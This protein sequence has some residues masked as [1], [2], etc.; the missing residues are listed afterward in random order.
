MKRKSLLFLLLFAL[1]APWAANAQNTLTVYEDG[2]EVNEYVPFYGYYADEEQQ[3]QMIF[4]ATELADMVGQEITEMVFYIDHV[5]GYYSIGNWIVSLGET[6][7]TT[8]EELDL[9]TPL[10]Q[11]YSGAMN[12]NS[13]ETLM[14]VTFQVGYTYRGGNLL[15][16]FNHPE[17]ASYKHYYFTGAEVTGAAYTYDAQRDFLPKV[18]F[19]HQTP[20]AC[21]KPAFVTANCVGNSATVTWTSDATD[22]N[23]EV[24]GVVTNNVTNPY[25][26]NNLDLSTTY[27]VRVQAVCDGGEVS[28]WSDPVSF[29]T[30]LCA[31][32]DVCQISYVLTD[33]YGDGWNGNYINV[34]DVATN[35][36]LATWTINGGSSASGTLAV[37]DRREIQFQYVY[38]GGY[39]YPG[40]NSW[41]ITDVN[42]EVIWEYQSPSASMQQ[43]YTVS[44]A[45]VSCRKPTDLVVS[46]ITTRTAD[47]SWTENGE[48]EAWEVEVVGSFT[49]TW[50]A[51]ENPYTIVGLEPETHYTVRVRAICGEDDYSDWSNEISF[52]TEPLCYAPTNLT[53]SDITAYSANISWTSDNTNFEMRYCEDIRPI[54]TFDDSSLGDWTNIDADGDGYEWVLA[55]EV[56]GVYHNTGVN[57]T[58]NGHNSSY[59]FVISGS[60][61]NAGGIALTPD[62]YLVSP[63]VTLGGSISLWAQAQ[64]VSYPAEHFG[65]AVST[66]GNTNAD[67]FTTIWETTMTAKSIGAKANP[68]TTRSGESL[69]AGTWYHFTIDLSA[70]SGKVMWPFAT[71]AAATSS[72]L[73]WTTSLLK[74]LAS[75]C[76]GLMWKIPPILKL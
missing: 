14:T 55:S 32:E 24:N 40:E 29:T 21:P 47:L 37:C 62:N 22:F 76:L 67:D 36:V 42:G 72:S 8:L 75:N 49:T 30:G 44:C 46:N 64:D 43:N 5:S 19:T 56:A 7:A 26:L 61:T 63:Q 33:S 10:S 57:V 13:D 60:Y 18:T 2:T 28:E 20:A 74:S 39:T 12:F 9:T 4:P 1:L 53:T 59:D 23:I 11:V 51:T 16:E 50:N 70:Y 38:P 58:G 65:I 15:V 45:V 25:V 35:I 3:N 71:S 17:A 54:V 52:T 66:T 68:G 27:E 69:R 73:M 48:A 41:V 34:V 31:V 6:T